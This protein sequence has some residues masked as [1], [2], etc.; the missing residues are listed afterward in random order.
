MLKEAKDHIDAAMLLQ[1]LVA[2]LRFAD[3]IALFSY[4]AKGLQYLQTQL[5]I[6]CS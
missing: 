5:D 2:I 4:S 6:L 3:D 1:S